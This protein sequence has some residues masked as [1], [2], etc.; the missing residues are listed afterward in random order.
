MT[1]ASVPL[2]ASNHPESFVP[3]F[4]GKETDWAIATNC[5]GISPTGRLIGLVNCHAK[6]AETA[7]NP[8][9][10]T[11]PSRKHRRNQE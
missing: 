5:D 6:K 2:R 1:A 3:S 7:T 4:A 9:K 10:S 8:T 11:A